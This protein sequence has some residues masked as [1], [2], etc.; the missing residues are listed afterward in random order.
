MRR[1]LTSVTTEDLA[2]G[3][4]LSTNKIHDLQTHFKPTENFSIYTLLILPPFKRQKRGF[5]KEEALRLLGTNSVK[6]T[7]EQSQRDSEHRF[8][9]RG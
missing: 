2:E 9:Q 8:C 7:F 1:V 4:R 6:E 3:P 5:I